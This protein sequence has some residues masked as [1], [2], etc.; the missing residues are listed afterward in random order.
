VNAASTEDTAISVPD[1]PLEAGVIYSA[2]AVGTAAARDLDVILTE[3][4]AGGGTSSDLPETGG[5][6]TVAFAGA[7]AALL[8]AGALLALQ[9]RQGGNAAS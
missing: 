4:S 5:L 8:A 1:V 9:G 3:D 2:F 7:A 6:S